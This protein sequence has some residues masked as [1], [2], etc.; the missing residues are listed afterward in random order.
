MKTIIESE[1]KTIKQ[2]ER[3]E[4]RLRSLFEIFRVSLLGLYANLCII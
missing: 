2:A 1:T 4:E 3:Q